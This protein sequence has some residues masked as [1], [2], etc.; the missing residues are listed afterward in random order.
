MLFGNPS[1]LIETLANE[2]RKR[3]PQIAAQQPNPNG[4]KA[5]T[6]GVK[7]ALQEIGK[8]KGLRTFYTEAEQ[9]MKEFMLDVVWWAETSEG[10]ERQW[11]RS[12]SGV[13]LG[14]AM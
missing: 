13:I 9:G 11:V 12:L 4:N 3:I 7:K 6:I 10:K 14:R 8:A 1:I 2:L 5:Y